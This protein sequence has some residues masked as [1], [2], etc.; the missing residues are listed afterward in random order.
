M[1]N[2]LENC[3]SRLHVP[4]H[5]PRPKGLG[6]SAGFLLLLYVCKTVLR[7]WMGRYP[8]STSPQQ[9]PYRTN[10]EAVD[11]V[12]IY[13]GNIFSMNTEGFDDSLSFVKKKSLNTCILSYV[14]EAFIMIDCFWGSILCKCFI[15]ELLFLQ[16]LWVPIS[17]PSAEY[18]MICFF[19]KF[20][21]I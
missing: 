13:T 20:I 4:P 14:I 19:V 17:F 7:S 5:P 3:L 21:L 11:V 2:R 10:Q 1:V 15:H 9:T 6:M 18:A 8:F 16:K 12:S